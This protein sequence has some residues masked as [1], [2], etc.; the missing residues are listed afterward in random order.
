MKENSRRLSHVVSFAGALEARETD[1][2]NTPLTKRELE[3]ELRSFNR[4]LTFKL[5]IVTIV[6]VIVISLA[7]YYLAK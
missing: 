3:E 6:G 1:A 4:R 2:M 7:A 5:G